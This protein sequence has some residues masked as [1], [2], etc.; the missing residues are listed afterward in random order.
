MSLL[1]ILTNF[2]LL[3][4]FTADICDFPSFPELSK[5]KCHLF[6]AENSV[7]RSETMAMFKYG[8]KNVNCSE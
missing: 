8:R 1:N 6:V 7:I 2:L 3:N 5:K 4:S